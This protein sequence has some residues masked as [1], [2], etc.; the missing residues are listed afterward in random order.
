MHELSIAAGIVEIVEQ[1]VA[2]GRRADVRT[3]TVAVGDYSGVV[4]ESL[5]FCFEVVAGESG[6]GEARLEI[7]R[8]PVVLRCPGCGT[9]VEQEPPLPAC[10]GCGGKRM[11]MV[12]GSELQ[13]L[14]VE[15]EDSAEE[16]S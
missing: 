11:V 13:V 3:V 2:A 7:R 4:P 8:V 14:E 16:T 10:P 5:A 1:H 9:D 15:L 6:I 12:S